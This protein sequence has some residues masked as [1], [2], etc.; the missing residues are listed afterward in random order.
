MAE[1][2]RIIYD[3]DCPFCSSYVKHLRLRQQYDVTLVNARDVP[4]LYRSLRAAG[5]DLDQGMV[6]ELQGE[7]YFGA[8]CVNRLALLTTRAGA[9]NRLNAWIFRSPAR[10]RRLY[11]IMVRGRNLALKLLGRRKLAADL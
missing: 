6:L 1:P 3:G 10:T 9:F 5:H 11:P 2:L 8:D 7:R 4:E